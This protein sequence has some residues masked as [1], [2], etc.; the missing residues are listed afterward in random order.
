MGNGWLKYVFIE[1]A[2]A[3]IRSS[4]YCR[5]YFDRIKHCKDSN[6]AIVALA[7]RLFETA[8]KYLK[9]KRFYEERPYI[10]YAR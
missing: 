1:A 2:W 5:A 4:P 10:P 3:A 8:H 9:E 7:R 6:V